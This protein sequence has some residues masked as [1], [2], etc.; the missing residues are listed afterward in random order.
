MVRGILGLVNKSSK[1]VLEFQII[2]L[3]TCGAQNAWI[4]SK[5]L[6]AIHELAK[7]VILNQSK[8]S[9][10]TLNFLDEIVSQTRKSNP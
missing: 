10:P 7:V 4:N 1:E 9:H 3:L 8:K 5:H 6:K 2:R